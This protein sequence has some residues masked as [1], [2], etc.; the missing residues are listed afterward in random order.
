MNPYSSF[1][2]ISQ[3]YFLYESTAAKVQELQELTNRN[4]DNLLDEVY[5]Q[6]LIKAQVHLEQIKE[7]IEGMTEGDCFSIEEIFLKEQTKL[8]PLIFWFKE[9]SEAYEKIGPSIKGHLLLNRTEMTKLLENNQKQI[10]SFGNVKVQPA[11]PSVFEE[12]QIEHLTLN[13]IESCEIKDVW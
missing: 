1:K 7:V 2:D 13:G 11:D 4:F 3:L 12:Y 9:E 6:K 5:K 8:N 10:H